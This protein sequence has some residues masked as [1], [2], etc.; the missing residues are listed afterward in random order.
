MR[1]EYN[2]L[3]ERYTE[4]NIFHIC[5][6]IRPLWT[7]MYIILQYGI[8]LSSFHPFLVPFQTHGDFFLRLI[9]LSVE[10]GYFLWKKQ[11]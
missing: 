3:H 2:K 9:T 10:T 7:S 1:K 11:D 5:E 8:N 6:K 4:V